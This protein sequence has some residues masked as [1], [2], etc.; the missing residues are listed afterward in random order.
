[1]SDLKQ[2]LVVDDEPANIDLLVGLLKGS[3][4]VKVAT[5]GQRALKI[6]QKNKPDL[7]LLDVIMPEMDGHETCTE[8]LKLHS[9][10]PIILVTGNTS[11][12]DIE[13]GKA[14]GAKDVLGKPI[15][16]Q[17][18]QAAIEQWT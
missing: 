13:K 15:D 2:I 4:K 6:A 3:Y 18:I 12:E 7:V 17:A 1:M 16:P 11:A 10:L 14:L 9:D 5:G 8:L